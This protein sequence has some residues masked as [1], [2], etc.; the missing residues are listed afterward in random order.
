MEKRAVERFEMQI[1]ATVFIKDGNLEQIL[2][3]ETENIS[4]KGTLL[5]TDE[6]MPEG[7]RVEV[8]LY[9][10]LERLLSV[11][12]PGERILVRVRGTVVRTLRDA[13]AVQ[14]EPG[15]QIQPLGATGAE[16]TVGH[17]GQEAT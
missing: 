15:Y 12:G 17:R 13:V 16:F 2:T 5:H 11:I 3:L 6:P 4:S 14:F 10:P 7:V 8:E 1:P 9:L